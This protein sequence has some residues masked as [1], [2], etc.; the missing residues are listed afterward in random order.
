MDDVKRN[1]NQ[2]AFS[3]KTLGVQFEGIYVQFQIE[4]YN[5]LPLKLISNT[6]AEQGTQ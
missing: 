2:L 3:H 1:T 6:I 4:S 5:K